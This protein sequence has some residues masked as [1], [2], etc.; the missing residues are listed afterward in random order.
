[1][2]KLYSYKK[3]FDFEYKYTYG[4]PYATPDDVR[5]GI[6][7]YVGEISPLEKIPIPRQTKWIRWKENGKW[8][9]A[10]RN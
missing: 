7:T 2:N 10:L 9:F 8:V 3:R 5:Q 6:A 1:M 4:H